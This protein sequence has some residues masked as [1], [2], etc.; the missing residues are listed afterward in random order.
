VLATKPTLRWLIHW[1]W[2]ALCRLKEWKRSDLHLLP[3]EL[4]L[5][6]RS[7]RLITP[8][9]Y[10]NRISVCIKALA[11]W[12]SSQTNSRIWSS[13][14][15]SICLKEGHILFE[16]LL[17]FSFLI[18]SFDLLD[19][20]YFVIRLRGFLFMM[21]CHGVNT[22][23]LDSFF[24]N[25]EFEKTREDTICF[26]LFNESGCWYFSFVFAYDLCLLDS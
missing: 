24:S 20:Q 4:L 3:L 8:I 19:Q 22:D 7:S 6:I 13:K 10:I 11:R 18:L 15:W 1:H 17:G 14:A 23:W 21:C 5:H 25:S 9:V 26:K 2:R 12:V 16:I